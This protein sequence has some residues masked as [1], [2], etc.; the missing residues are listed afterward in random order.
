MN[1]LGSCSLF[2]VK[3]R[4]MCSCKDSFTDDYK[5][6]RRK[7]VQRHYQLLDVSF[8]FGLYFHKL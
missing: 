4:A 1:R 3:T 7:G 2:A 6:A 8:V 5:G